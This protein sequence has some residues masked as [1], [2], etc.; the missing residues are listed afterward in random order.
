M[1]RRL[2]S[3]VGLFK[4]HCQYVKM[5]IG[6]CSAECA[7]GRKQSRLRRTHLPGRRT[8]GRGPERDSHD[9]CGI[10]VSR[11]H[12]VAERARPGRTRG[13]HPLAVGAGHYLDFLLGGLLMASLALSVALCRERFQRCV[14]RYDRIGECQK[15]ACHA[16]EGLC[17]LR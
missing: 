15:Q 17:F 13:P 8:P 9:G 5:P 1:T 10:D 14:Y 6:N 3:N 12:T 11:A 16:Q 2:V 7:L 4:R